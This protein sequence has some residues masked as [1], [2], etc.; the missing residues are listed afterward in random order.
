M[1]YVVL[2]GEIFRSISIFKNLEM[3]QNKRVM[4]KVSRKLHID[5]A[6]KTSL[7]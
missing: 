2:G 3:K 5:H 6:V 1:K 4:L 7:K